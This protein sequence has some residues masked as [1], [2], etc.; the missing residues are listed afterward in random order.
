VES[1]R[2]KGGAPVGG[3]DG[4]HGHRSRC[5]RIASTEASGCGYRR[6]LAARSPELTDGLVQPIALE[7]GQGFAIREGGRTVGSGTVT[8]IIK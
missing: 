6:N 3:L 4:G 8:K 5:I 7:E 1:R 2:Q